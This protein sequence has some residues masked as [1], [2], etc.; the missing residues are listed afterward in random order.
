MLKY[1]LVCPNLSV[2][3]IQTTGAQKCPSLWGYDLSNA[4][5]TYTYP[6]NTKTQSV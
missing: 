5:Y 2:A 4:V 3:N 6:Y 1:N